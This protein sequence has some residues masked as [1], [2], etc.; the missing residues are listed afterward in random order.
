MRDDVNTVIERF[1]GS[2]ALQLPRTRAGAWALGLAAGFVVFGSIHTGLSGGFAAGSDSRSTVLQVVAGLMLG[3]GGA[4]GAL[5]G[6]ALWRRGE[7]SWLLGV[8][9]LAGLFA[10]VYLLGR[11]PG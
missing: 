11:L 3:C 6:E 2:G 7:R 1:L 9:L 10:A 8:P 5:A 4:A